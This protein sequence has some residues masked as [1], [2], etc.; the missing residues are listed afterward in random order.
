[1]SSVQHLREFISQRLTAAAEEIF[2]E[3]EKTIVQYEEEIDRQRGLLDITWKPQIKL[4]TADLP[5]E[6]GCKEE[7]D[8]LLLADQQ[9]RNQERN[10][11]VDPE[12]PEHPQIK[13]EQEELCT[14]MG[15]EQLLLKQET[16]TFMLTPTC[17]QSDFSET[18][19]NTDQLYSHNSPSSQNQEGSHISHSN[20]EDNSPVSESEL[21]TESGE[22]FV[23]PNFCGKPSRESYIIGKRQ[24]YHTSEKAFACQTCGKRFAQSCTLLRHTRIHT[25][26]K[27]FSCETCGKSFS[28]NSSLLTHMRIHTG[29]KL[30]PCEMCG[31]SFTQSGNLLRHMRIHT[32]DK[33]Y[34]CKTCGKNFT[35]S[36]NLLTHMRV[37]TG[38]KL[39]SCKICG[40]SFSQNSSLFTHMR[41]HT[42]ERPYSCG[43]CRKTFKQRSYLRLHMRIHTGEVYS[44]EICG[45]SFHFRGG[46][47][48]H[49]RTHTDEKL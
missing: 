48:T 41:I 31:K 39:Y 34:S 44:C 40:K 13:E 19:P 5:Q 42:G 4:H 28:Q 33:L 25:G 22:T 47:N 10:A 37:H 6:H 35:Q 3:F 18:E 8:R 38:E 9:L 17:Q 30:Y 20:S 21:T 11:S 29:E 2:S 46:L 1:M 43:I 49:M 15:G 14:T 32:G 16:D 36:G 23:K 7:E 26:E 12:A 24:R 45:K 27:M